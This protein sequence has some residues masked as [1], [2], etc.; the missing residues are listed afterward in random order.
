MLPTDAQLDEATLTA[1]MA[2]G[3]LVGLEYLP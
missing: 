2:S 1:I 3:A